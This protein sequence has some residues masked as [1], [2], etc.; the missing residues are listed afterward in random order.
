MNERG[1]VVGMLLFPRY[2]Q[3]PA[4]D[5]AKIDRTLGSW[6]VATY[7]LSTCATL[8]EAR[9]ALTDGSV[10]VSNAE[11]TPFGMVLPVHY[12]IADASGAVLIAEYVDGKLAAPRTTRSAF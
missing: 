2:A 5:A 8:D 4:A 1:L 9:A 6:E 12:Y 11:F 7:L 3:Y 10:Y